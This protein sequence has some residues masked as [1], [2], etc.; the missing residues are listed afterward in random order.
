MPKK[1]FK[2]SE[3]T[4]KKRSLTLTGRKRSVRSQEWI[5]NLSKSCKGRKAWNKGHKKFRLKICGLCGKKF[6]EKTK[7]CGS[8]CLHCFRVE[9]GKKSR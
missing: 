5:D 7:F 2:Q 6:E 4:K 9:F 1:G 3:E 8:E